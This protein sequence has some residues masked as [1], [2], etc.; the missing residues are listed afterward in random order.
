MVLNF[1]IIIIIFFFLGFEEVVKK[2]FKMKKEEILEQAERW[3]GGRKGE[4]GVEELLGR[5]KEV[6]GGL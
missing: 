2:H 3:L 4:K 1:F 5:V 6:V